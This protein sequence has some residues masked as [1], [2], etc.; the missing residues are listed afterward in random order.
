MDLLK[1][2]SEANAVSGNE[3]YFMRDIAP[4]A[5]KKYSQMCIRDRSLR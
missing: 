3:A 4:E 2:I 1:E 5:V